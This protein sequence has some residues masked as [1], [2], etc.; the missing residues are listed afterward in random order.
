MKREYGAMLVSALTRLYSLRDGTRYSQRE[1]M[2]YRIACRNELTDPRTSIAALAEINRTKNDTPEA[3]AR[4]KQNLDISQQ[5]Q[6]IIQLADPR[7]TASP[8]DEL[9]PTMKDIN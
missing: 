5:P 8:L 1:L 4:A 6:V 2:L 3:K 7:L 9:P